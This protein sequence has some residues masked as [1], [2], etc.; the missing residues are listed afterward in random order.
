MDSFLKTISI[1][2]NG[3]ILLIK[4]DDGLEI[5]G[6]IDTIYETYEELDEN[7]LE[8]FKY[9]ACA[10]MVLEMVNLT[11]GGV[12]IQKGSLMEIS[13]KNPPIEIC[14]EDGKVIWNNK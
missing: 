3:T 13:I 11:E 10:F 7:G 2:P 5:K 4:W 1:F 9:F 12:N 8:I 6:N 14:L